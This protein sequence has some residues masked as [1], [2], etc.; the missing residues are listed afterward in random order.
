MIDIVTVMATAAAACETSD[1]R[2][3]KR[4]LVNQKADLGYERKGDGP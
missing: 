4:D 2:L 1:R 3:E